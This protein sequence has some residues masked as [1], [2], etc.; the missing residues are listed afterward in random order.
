M[1]DSSKQYDALGEFAE[2]RQIV[3]K[4]PLSVV[5]TLTRN[6]R[7]MH[8]PLRQEDFLAP[9]EGQV[10]GL[11]GSAIKKILKDHGVNQTLA[12]EGGRT[13]R[14]SID[15]MRAYVDCLNDIWEE[16]V[17]DLPAIEKFWILR[18]QGYFSASPFRLRLDKSLSIRALVRELL[19]QAKKRQ[20]ER[21]GS[22][23]AGTVIQ[24]LVAA[25]IQCLLGADAPKPH[26]ASSA[27]SSRN[28]SGDFEIGD[29][30]IHVTLSPSEALIEKCVE[31]LHR[32]KTPIIVTGNDSI[33]HALTL[34]EGKLI[35][36]RIEVWGYEQFISTRLRTHKT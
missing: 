23:I 2:S 25:K 35:A 11:G 24:H 1:K 13:S 10:A 16:G 6:V 8:F 30:I 27:D 14:G 34:A 5:L 4:G 26:G 9:K 29:E 3:G 15:I 32:G 31:N 12:S 19:S 20:A 17:L 28:T 7:T 18:V 36:D 22:T 21:P 33:S